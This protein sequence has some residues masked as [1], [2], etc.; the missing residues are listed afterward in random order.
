MHALDKCL[1]VV[2]ACSY[3]CKENND[4]SQAIDTDVALIWLLPN[5]LF[6]ALTDNKWHSNIR[7]SIFYATTKF[8]Y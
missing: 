5:N 2:F 1:P 8:T 6:I 4:Y 3:Y 7:R